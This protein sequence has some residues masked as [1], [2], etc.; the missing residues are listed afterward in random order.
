[1]LSRLKLTAGHLLANPNRVR[2]ILI[3]STLVI[4]ALTGGAPH[5][6]GGG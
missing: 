2:T 4:A 6:H 3:L 5:D 1:M